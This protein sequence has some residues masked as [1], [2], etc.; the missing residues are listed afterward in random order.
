[1]VAYVVFL[2]VWPACEGDDQVQSLLFKAKRLQKEYSAVLTPYQICCALHIRA[3]VNLEK[4]LSSL[5]F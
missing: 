3:Q 2:R 1:M 5:M 4:Q